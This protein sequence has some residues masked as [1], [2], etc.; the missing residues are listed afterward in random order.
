[1]NQ[2]A[3]PNLTQR[4]QVE[5]SLEAIE[6]RMTAVDEMMEDAT[7]ATDT[8]LDYVTAQVI[9]QHVS[10]LNGSKIQLEQE[11]QRLANIIAVWD[12]A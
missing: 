1:M 4:Q 8:A 6:L 7:A 10:I 11:R 2:Y 5:A 12:A 3:N 9:A